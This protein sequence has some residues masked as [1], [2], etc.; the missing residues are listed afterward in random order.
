MSET[1]G[2][3]VDGG[4]EGEDGGALGLAG[5]VSL[6]TNA[7]AGNGLSSTSDSGSGT[8][9]SCVDGDSF[10]GKSVKLII[11]ERSAV[12]GTPVIG[13]PFCP[14]DLAEIVTAG[15][16]L[17]NRTILDAKTET[18]E[19]VTRNNTGIE[20]DASFESAFFTSDPL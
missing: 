18:P 9:C 20:L 14:A 3:L 4:G 17:I 12:P 8:F 13:F 6:C 11:A 10:R 1:A 19:K 2:K 16:T 15:S 5:G 7:S